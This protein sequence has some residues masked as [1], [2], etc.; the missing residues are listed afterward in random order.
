MPV[1]FVQLLNNIY[2]QVGLLSNPG[3]L[4][5]IAK[6]KITASNQAKGLPGVKTLLLH[7]TG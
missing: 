2:T 7:E 4:A 1:C 3:T 5:K 6:K